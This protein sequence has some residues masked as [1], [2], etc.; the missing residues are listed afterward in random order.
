MIPALCTFRLA[1]CHRRARAAFG[2]LI[3]RRAINR[4]REIATPCSIR[5]R[6][7]HF[8]YAA[9]KTLA[10]AFLFTRSLVLPADPAMT[11]VRESRRH[12]SSAS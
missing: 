4:R 12:C 11:M 7:A 1:I 5:S 9:D 3:A 8:S 10:S 6:P 2:I